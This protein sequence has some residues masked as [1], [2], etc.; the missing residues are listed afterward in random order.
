MLPIVWILRHSLMR[1]PT[2]N[3]Q[4]YYR[5][6]KLDISLTIYRHRHNMVDLFGKKL[7][8]ITLVHGQKI[9]QNHYK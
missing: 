7:F 8:D 1:Q 3:N 9:N 5:Q 2:K 4:N 6:I